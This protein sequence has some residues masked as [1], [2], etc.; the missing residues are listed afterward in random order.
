MSELPFVTEQTF[1]DEVVASPQPV[2]VDVTAVWC[3]PC[4]MLDPLVRQLANE[5][6]DKVKVVKIDAD[7]NPGLLMQYG[8]LGIPTLMLFKGGDIKERMT[9]FVP[10]DR[11]VARLSPHLA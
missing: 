8:I 6:N 3:A 11:L 4:K 2:L 5:W 1:Q 7:Q 9:G 10:K